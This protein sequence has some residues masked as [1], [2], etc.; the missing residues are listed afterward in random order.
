MRG[1]T[2]PV[3]AVALMYHDVTTPGRD[4][5]SGFPGGDAARYKLRP[6]QFRTHLQALRQRL[7]VPPATIDSV[8][9]A[10]PATSASPWFLTFDDGGVSAEAIADAL[11]ENGWHGHLFM[12]T[13]YIDRPGF[14]SP[15]AL[16]RLHARGHVI[17]SHSHT[18][19]LRMARCSA[20]RLHEEWRRSTEVL[21]DLLGERV[22]TASVPG[23][24]YSDLVAHTASEAGITWLFTSEPTTR[25]RN[26]ANCCIIGRYAVQ[27]STSAA[28]AAALVAGDALPRLRYRAAWNVRQMCK[29]FGGRFY[30]RARDRLLGR[31]PGVTWGDE[32]TPS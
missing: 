15:A 14:L 12:T 24:H 19:P 3:Q 6:D 29:T 8:A 13:A 11:E 17:G 7:S 27:R 20:A 23:G 4:D 22:V 31:S 28:T 21:S 5:A 32:L 26:V 18:H 2:H 1:T 16:R 9:A 10:P 30:L 25:V